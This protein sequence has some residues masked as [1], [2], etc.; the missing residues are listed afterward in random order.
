MCNPQAKE[1]TTTMIIGNFT[2]SKQD[3]LYSGTIQTMS[4]CHEDVLFQPAK[5]Q[6]DKSPDYRITV[7]GPQGSVELGAAWKRK[8][9]KGREYLSV[10]LDDPAN[11]RPFFA[12]LL[13][14]EKGASAILVW[15]RPARRKTKAA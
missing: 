14:S 15:S 9:A 6:G 4:G 13:P 12:A 10:R 3:K 11:P 8:S 1:G 7:D 2:Y 5:K